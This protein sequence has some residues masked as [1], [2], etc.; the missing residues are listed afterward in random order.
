V[1]ELSDE[2][3]GRTDSCR[4]STGTVILTSLFDRPSKIEKHRRREARAVKVLMEKQKPAVEFLM[5][6]TAT[7]EASSGKWD[8]AT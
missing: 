3:D 2:F 5:E 4:R 8:H 6:W 7:M 1:S